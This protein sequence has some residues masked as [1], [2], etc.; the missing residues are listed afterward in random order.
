[1]NRDGDFVVVLPAGRDY[2]S[3]ALPEIHLDLLELWAAVDRRID[4]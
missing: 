4:G 1:V 2:R 3:P